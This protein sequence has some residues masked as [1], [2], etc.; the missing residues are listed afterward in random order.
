MAFD[1]CCYC[2]I[3][4]ADIHCCRITNTAERGGLGYNSECSKLRGFFVKNGELQAGELINIANETESGT[5]IMMKKL[6]GMGLI[7]EDSENL[8]LKIIN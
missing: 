5:R 3:A 2:R 1:N 8:L 7:E 6:M 4:N